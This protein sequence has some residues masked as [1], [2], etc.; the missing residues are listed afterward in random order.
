MCVPSVFSLAVRLS[1]VTLTG[2]S[3]V[4]V[5]VH[6]WDRKQCV[7]IISCFG[8]HGGVLS[9]LLRF[10]LIFT[11]CRGMAREKVNVLMVLTAVVIV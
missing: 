9:G 10:C 1:W 8:G 5:L 11:T 4:I 6:G 2:H 3:F 7:A